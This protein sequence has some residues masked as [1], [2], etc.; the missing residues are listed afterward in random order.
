MIGYLYCALAT[1]VVILGDYCIKLA[2]E[3][4]LPP[5][6]W[7][8]LAGFLLYGASALGWYMA[9]RSITLA[10][11]GVAFSAFSILALCAMGVFL[12]DE[13][14]AP[15]EYLGILAA[16]LSLVLMARFV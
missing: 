15:R 6:S 8:V 13:Q 9:M 5:M 2:A 1:L 7:P 14:L 10:Q 4:D 3:R 16:L 11:V 12:F